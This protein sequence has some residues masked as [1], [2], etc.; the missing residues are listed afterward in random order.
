MADC[1]GAPVSTGWLASLLPAAAERLEGFLAAARS[2][3]AAADMAHFDETGGRVGAK[4]WW[5]HVAC[6]DSLTVYHLASGRGKDSIDAGEGRQHPAGLRRGRGP[7]RA[8]LLPQVR[9]DPRPLR[10]PPSSGAGR[11]LS[12]IHI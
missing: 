2:H 3:L 6:T 7:R 10:R 9:R 8:H 4:L 12:L 1:F 11:D 5:F